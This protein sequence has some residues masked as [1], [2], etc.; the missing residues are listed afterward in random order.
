[1][2]RPPLHGKDSRTLC[3]CCKAGAIPRSEI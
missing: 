1:M 2:A 3:E